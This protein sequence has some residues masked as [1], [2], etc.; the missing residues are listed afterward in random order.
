MARNTKIKEA[1]I[2]LQLSVKFLQQGLMIMLTDDHVSS[3]C[4]KFR[5]NRRGTKISEDVLSTFEQLETQGEPVPSRE[6][7]SI[8]SQCAIVVST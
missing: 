4:Q 1:I 3:S 2:N 8:F 6:I 7:N 5:C